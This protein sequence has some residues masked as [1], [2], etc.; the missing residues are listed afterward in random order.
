MNIITP[1]IVHRFAQKLLGHYDSAFVNRLLQGLSQGF[2]TGMSA[3]P[4]TSFECKNLLSARSQP[5]IVNELLQYELD[6]G[7]LAGPYDRPPYDLYRVSPIGVAQGKYSLKNR[8]IVDLSAPHNNDLQPSINDFIDKEEHSLQYVKIEDAIKLIQSLGKGAIMCK[9][10]IVDAFKLIPIQPKY[11]PFYGIKWEGQY[12]FYKRLV[13]GSR[14]SPKIFD[15][16]SEA[17]CWIAKEKY[18]MRHILHLLD[19][20]LVIDTST[21]DGHQT[22]TTLIQIFESLGIPLS[23]KKTVGP[24]TTMEYLGIELD[25]VKMEARLPEEKTNRI[26]GLIKDMSQRRSCTKRELLSLLGHLNFAARVIP[27]GRSFVSY[28]LQLAH[29]V[30][31]LHHH[32]NITSECRKDLDMWAQFLAQWNG[33]SFFLDKTVLA[34]DIE[35]YT[36]ASSKCGF[37]GYFH[38]RWFQGHWPNDF[39]TLGNDPLSMALLELYPI[40]VAAVLWGHEWSRK[41]IKFWCDNEATVHILRKRR[42]QSQ[43]I[44]KLMRKL[45]WISA[46]NCFV[47]ISEHVPGSQNVI[48]DSLSRFQMTR[49]RQ[50]AT[51]A[52][53]NPEPCP[54]LEQLILY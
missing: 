43:M 33:I 52:R 12:Y 5:H 17:I 6:N 18:Q 23:K 48:A 24:S 22:M 30:E 27:A 37:G 4:R 1:I 40:V 51:G 26:Y 25:S 34:Q 14:S 16:L 54:T 38:G 31:K 28:L 15:Q 9:T 13:F 42:S 47:I 36:D 10:D 19:D 46:I 32:V 20:F 50:A 49:F 8:L 35:L 53:T 7:Y 3:L 11:Q 41:T 29:S 44:M 45:T 21:S 2:D 39:Q